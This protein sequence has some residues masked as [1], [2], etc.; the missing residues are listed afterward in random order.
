MEVRSKLIEIKTQFSF[1]EPLNFYLEFSL[2]S[3]DP[4]FNPIIAPYLHGQQGHDPL[5]LGFLCLVSC[6]SL[7]LFL[8]AMEY[9][10]YHKDVLPIVV[11]LEF[12]LSFLFYN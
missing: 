11:V 6:L 3:N 5:L 9:L 4:Q 1:S 8:L 7:F 12:K 2:L 10:I